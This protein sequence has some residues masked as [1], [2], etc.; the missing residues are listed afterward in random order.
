M[1]RHGGRGVLIGGIAASLLGRPRFTADVDAMLL[2]STE[3][4]D[5]LIAAA[6]E[7]G[8]VPRN[9]DAATFARRHRILLLHHTTSGISVDLSLGALPF[10]EEMVARSHLHDMGP[11]QVRLPSPEDLIIMKAIPRR[12]QDVQDIERLLQVYP[13]LDR[14]RIRYWTQAFADVLEMPEVWDDIAPLLDR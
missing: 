2:A 11:L 1:D 5:Q 8:L 9:E 13:D 7:E 10:E 3:D 14:D 4:V 6:A 12:P